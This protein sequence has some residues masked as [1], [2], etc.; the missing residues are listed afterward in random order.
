MDKIKVTDKVV[1]YWH[2]N[3]LLLNLL[4]MGCRIR[5]KGVDRGVNYGGGA[6]L[7]RIQ[8]EKRIN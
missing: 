4:Q 6:F 1:V 8:S 7:D 5:V 2:T 3:F